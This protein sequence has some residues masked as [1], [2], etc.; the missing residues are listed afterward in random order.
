MLLTGSCWHRGRG[1][2]KELLEQLSLISSAAD[3]LTLRKSPMFVQMAHKLDFVFAPTI[4]NCLRGQPIPKLDRKVLAND[5]ANLDSNEQDDGV[6]FIGVVS[7]K[8]ELA[9][10]IK[11]EV[12]VLFWLKIWLYFHVPLASAAFIT[13]V[14]HIISV[15]YYW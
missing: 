13:M 10:L 4:L 14:I 6:K 3:S 15:F 1:S 11:E 5:V 9:N 2:L 7:R 8:V 12:K